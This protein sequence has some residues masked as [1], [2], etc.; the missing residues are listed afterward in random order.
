VQRAPRKSKPIKLLP[1]LLD[2]L[3]LQA[4]WNRRLHTRGIARWI[5]EN[6]NGTFSVKLGSLLPT[7]RKMVKKKWIR[8]QE[9]LFGKRKAVYY[10]LDFEGRYRLNAE[11]KWWKRVSEGVWTAV[12]TPPAREGDADFHRWVRLVGRRRRAMLDI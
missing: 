12:H 4:L 8:K 7:L 1:G 2:L 10:Y 6:T 11:R 9:G 3:V 5:Y